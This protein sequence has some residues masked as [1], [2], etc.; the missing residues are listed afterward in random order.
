MIVAGGQQRDSACIHSSQRWCVFLRSDAPFR[1]IDQPWEFRLIY[2]HSSHHDFK[3]VSPLNQPFHLENS[4]PDTI[5][6]LLKVECREKATKML[7][8]IENN[9]NIHQ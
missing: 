8:K 7:R 4:V 3:P 5:P 9:L 2:T 6:H 1:H